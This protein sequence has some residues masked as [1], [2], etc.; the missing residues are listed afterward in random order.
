MSS[1]VERFQK[2]FISQGGFLHPAVELVYGAEKGISLFVKNDEAFE[3]PSPG[4]ILASCPHEL[5]LSSLNA[6]K[7]VSPLFSMHGTHGQIS[8]LPS[9]VLRDAGPRFIAAILLCVEYLRGEQSF[10]AN[11]IDILPGPPILDAGESSRRGLGEVGGP[12]WWTEEELKCLEGTNIPRGVD[13]LIAN[14]GKLWQKWGGMIST[15][16][17]GNALNGLDW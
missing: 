8:E 12:I 16:A 10:W 15:W 2:W 13:D 11:Y 9:D 5:S 14:W 17:K 7:D 4:T 6:F 1:A 3:V